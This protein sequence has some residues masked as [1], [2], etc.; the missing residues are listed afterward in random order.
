MSQCNDCLGSVQLQQGP[1]GPAGD[2]STVA[3]PQGPQGPQGND[4]NDGGE[5]PEG[6]TGGVILETLTS[7]SSDVT[8]AS[9]ASALPSGTP[10][11]VTGG[12]LDGDGDTLRLEVQQMPTIDD[13]SL[14]GMNIHI[15]AQ[16]VEIGSISGL[17]DFPNIEVLGPFAYK[18]KLDLVRVNATTLRVESHLQTFRLLGGIVSNYVS[19]VI[20]ADTKLIGNQLRSS[21][22]LTVNLA[23]DFNIDVKL[24]TDNASRPTKLLSAKLEL[25]NKV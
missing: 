14:A 8:A 13:S 15:A 9:Y 18:L 23:V 3:G 1:A 20:A 5:G 12:T 24:R 2:A 21:Q 22:T 6:P 19:E 11:T 17:F 7:A 4:G 25:L 10:W 16:D